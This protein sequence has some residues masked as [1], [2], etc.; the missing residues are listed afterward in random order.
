MVRV[1]VLGELALEELTTQLADVLRARGELWYLQWTLLE[2][3]SPLP[4]G[5]GSTRAPGGST[6]R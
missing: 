6:R 5:G 4:P 2:S 1:R 3:A